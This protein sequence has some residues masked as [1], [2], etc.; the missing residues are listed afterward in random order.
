MAASK[1][2]IRKL[3]KAL[4]VARMDER[5]QLLLKAIGQIGAGFRA[6]G[7]E[8]ALNLLP[9]KGLHAGHMANLELVALIWESI[10]GLGF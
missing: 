3:G 4:R 8:N 5:H 7:Q 10:W 6:R 2:L 1:A 9:I